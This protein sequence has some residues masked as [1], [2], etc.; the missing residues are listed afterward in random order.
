MPAPSQPAAPAQVPRSAAHLGLSLLGLAGGLGA[1]LVLLQWGPALDALIGPLPGDL[2]SIANNHLLI[3][4]VGCGVVVAIIGGGELFWQRSYRNPGSGLAPQ[5]LRPFDAGR[6]VVRL[7]GFAATLAIIGFVYWLFPEYSLD[8]N[9]FYGPFWAY[10]TALAWVVVPLAPF[11]FAWIQ[12]R[13]HQPNDGY[14]QLGM[15]VLGR[16]CIEGPELRNHFM[17]WTVK[18]FFLPL[19]AVYLAGEVGSLG[20]AYLNFR[21]DWH[22]WYQFLYD[23]GY[24]VDLL[25]C[26]V[27]YTITLRLFDSH[28]R[29]TEPTAFGWVIALMCYQP[30][31]SIIGGTYLHYD[32]SVYWDNWLAAY[33]ALRSLW[34]AAIIVLVFIY[35]LAT[36]SFGMRFSNLT[37]RGVIT[38]GPYRFTKHPAYLS[39]NLSWWIISV[40][41]VW[42]PQAQWYDALRN[43]CLIGLLNLVYYLRARTEENHLSLRDPD[44]VAY[45]LWMEEHGIM[46]WVGR[47]FP[48][49]RYKPPAG[50]A[51]PQAQA[52]A[53]P[54]EKPAKLAKA[55]RR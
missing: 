46:R 2:G 50:A 33:P 4:M 20:A 52:P 6:L 1:I 7:L 15:L 9:R 44:Y 36:V 22:N 54:R 17:G 40:P 38:S 5:P 3:A 11:Y 49:F 31:Y 30:F 26:V 29:S 55:A 39:K 53:P 23:I 47:L 37:Y 43:C 35:G 42:E 25:F 8:R 48:I 16:N 34:A 45:A 24:M 10:I 41:W 19:M 21:T 28:I 32:D 14:W 12:R 13:L 27:G 51:A 18:A